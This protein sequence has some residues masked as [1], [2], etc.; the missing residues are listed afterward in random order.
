MPGPEM[1]PSSHRHPEV[2][3][4]LE[5]LVAEGWT[6]RREGHWGR[7]Y[8]PC[9]D[10]GCTTIP[11]GGTLPKPDWVA[12]KIKRLASRCPLDLDDP[13]RSLAGKPRASAREKRDA[14]GP[15]EKS[16]KRGRKSLP[17]GSGRR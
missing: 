1:S 15:P 10:G 5:D 16:G 13:R 12:K 7:L 2:R 6:L 14:V 17:P 4:V 9:K 8:C 11:V 3:R